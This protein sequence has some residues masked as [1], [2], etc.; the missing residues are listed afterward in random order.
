MREAALI[1]GLTGPQVQKMMRVRDV[2]AVLID[3]R[4][5][6]RIARHA[7]TDR[8]SKST[9]REMLRCELLG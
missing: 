6:Y 9:V 7:D 2:A 5:L 3:G 4:V 1:R 8:K